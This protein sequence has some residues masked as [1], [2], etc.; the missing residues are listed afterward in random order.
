MRQDVRADKL[1]GRV[2]E[3]LRR[4]AVHAQQLKL[5]VERDIRIRRF[6]IEIAIPA[7][8]LDQLFLDPQAF[9]LGGRAG[10]EN[11][12]DEKQPR[13]WRHRPLVKDR[14]MAEHRSFTVQQR[15]AEIALDSHVREILVVRKLVLDPQGMV[16]QAA[17]HDILARRSGQVK[18]DVFAELA[19][20]PVGERSHPLVAAGKLGDE[21]VANADRSG[22][23][24]YQ[25]LEEYFTRVSGS[26]LDNRS[27]GR[28]LLVIGRDSSLGRLDRVLSS[29]V[30]GRLTS[31][32]VVPRSALLGQAA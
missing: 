7:L 21:S 10:R 31:H 32:S 28:D 3:K 5:S 13:L 19:L 29:R 18:L 12:E 14:Q 16:A 17:A 30:F 4:P 26:P 22:K 8:T 20:A 6:F 24:P 2:V 27:Q 25:R 15:N 23:V 9:Q 11:P 1:R